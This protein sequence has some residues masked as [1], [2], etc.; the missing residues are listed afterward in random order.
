LAE[1][2]LGHLFKMLR[3]RSFVFSGRTFQVE[4]VDDA[5]AL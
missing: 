1:T 3:S 4:E 5:V 2:G